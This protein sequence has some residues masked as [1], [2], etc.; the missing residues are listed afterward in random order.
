MKN[1]RSILVGVGIAISVISAFV[2]YQKTNSAITGIDIINP[3]RVSLGKTLYAQQCAACH[4]KN[5][6]GQTRNWRQPLPDGSFPAPPHDAS[7]HTWHHPGAVLFDVTKFSRTRSGE[8]SS[9]SNM[10]AF[11]PTLSDDE[12]W[13]VLSYIKSQWPEA[14]QQHHDALNQQHRLL[15]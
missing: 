1:T 13:A 6:E 4:G 2:M 3:E 11:G 15:K 12:I 7:G 10:P 14:I 5:L 9:K 8:K